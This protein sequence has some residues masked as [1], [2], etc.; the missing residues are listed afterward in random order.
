[1]KEIK[2][3]RIP[4]QEVNR[5]C[6]CKYHKT[7]DEKLEEICQKWIDKIEDTITK[8]GAVGKC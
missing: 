4:R 6:F 2:P 8:E 5:F 7:L 1:M 3:K